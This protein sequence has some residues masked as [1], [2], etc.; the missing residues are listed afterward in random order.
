[1]SCLLIICG[2]AAVAV[3]SPLLRRGDLAAGAAVGL[4]LCAAFAWLASATPVSE[5]NT[6]GYTLWWGSLVG[7]WVWL[8]LLWSIAELV[9][10]WAGA[11]GRRGSG[12][13]PRTWLAQRAGARRLPPAL[14]P[15]VALVAVIGAGGAVA[16]LESADA[17][18]A[19]FRALRAVTANLARSVPRGS[20]VLLTQR[21]FATIPLEP[22]V[23]YALRRQGVRV[24]ASG[25]GLRLGSWYEL[26][27]RSYAVAVDLSEGDH[28]DIHPARVLTRVRLENAP[29]LPGGAGR[30]LITLSLARPPQRL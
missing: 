20:T 29:W 10:T 12:A 27:R 23:K 18:Q 25:A 13:R 19:E 6:L 16:A 15:T 30:H 21:S 9:R 26:G 22:T 14:A 3:L 7:M 2:L 1:V 11:L 17:H 4:V 8:M 5:V 24:L 28:P